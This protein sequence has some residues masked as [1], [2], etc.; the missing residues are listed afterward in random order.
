MLAVSISVRHSRSRLMGHRR[1]LA[2][3]M[4][5]RTLD[6][7][8]K[9]IDQP[10]TS[11][12]A[13]VRGARLPIRYAVSLRSLA[14]AADELEEHLALPCPLRHVASD[15]VYAHR[16]P[17][18]NCCTVAVWTAFPSLSSR[19]AFLSEQNTLLLLSKGIPC[20]PNQDI[21]T[22]SRKHPYA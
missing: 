3:R 17:P 12:R 4:G 21:R 11:P 10:L 5:K 1:E 14:I 16:L 9:G 19:S 22:L 2:K 15:S 6:Q 18:L 20:F 8:R 7:M 13:Q